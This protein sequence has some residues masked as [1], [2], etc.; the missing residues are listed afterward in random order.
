VYG[1]ACEESERQGKVNWKGTTD[2][3][4]LRACEESERQEKGRGAKN[5]SKPQSMGHAQTEGWR[6]RVTVVLVR[7]QCGG[8]VNGLTS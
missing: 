2:A 7:P 5:Q 6:E 4:C 8:R 3:P 1:S